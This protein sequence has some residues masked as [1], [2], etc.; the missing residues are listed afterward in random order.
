MSFTEAF[1]PVLR[2]HDDVLLKRLGDLIRIILALFQ[3]DSKGSI[4]VHDLRSHIL[5][6]LLGSV[7][8]RHRKRRLF[9]G[10]GDGLYVLGQ[11]EADS[12]CQVHDGYTFIV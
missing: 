7:V 1:L 6:V 5:A 8:I 12:H 4:H 10:A 9:P 3:T 11:R 2:R